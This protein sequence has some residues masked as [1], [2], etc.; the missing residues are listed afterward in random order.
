MTRTE[1]LSIVVLALAGSSCTKDDWGPEQLGDGHT[2]QAERTAVLG[3]EVYAQYCAG[4]HGDNGDGEGPAARFLDPKPR[5]F[6]TGKLKFAG[7]MA[8]EPPR[9]EDYIR[10]IERGLKG[11]AMPSFALLT[12]QER[13]AVVAYVRL[14]IDPKRRKPAG[15]L[16]AIPED[17]WTKDPEAGIAV[18]KR[19]YH[20][21][22]KCWSC[23][24]GYADAN[25]VAALSREAGL[26]KAEMRSDHYVSLSSESSWGARIRAPDFLIDR[27]KTGHD[28]ED[29]VRVI[30][31]GVGGTAMP[32][33]AGALRP[34]ELWGLA[35]YVRS[36]T[37]R[38]G[39]PEAVA[40][41][42]LAV[43]REVKR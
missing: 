33:W 29:L 6:R 14:F 26:A 30:Q 25:E 10:T 3:R 27:V 24:P 19:V 2:S 39:T 36:L 1:C 42:R 18:G 41:R 4:C 35:Y 20:T 7:V 21:S 23:H 32:T 43:Q 16:I 13:A 9:D 15:T 5:D 38:R 17:P 37:L 34:K 22:A 12:Q 28:P 11:T 40:T 8:G 31:A